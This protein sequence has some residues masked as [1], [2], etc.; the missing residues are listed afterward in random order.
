MMPHIAGLSRLRNLMIEESGGDPSA[1]DPHRLLA[2]F[3][4]SAPAREREALRR[5]GP[6]TLTVR[7]LEIFRDLGM[8]MRA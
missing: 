4:A 5:L 6:D 1:L 3:K 8:G 7:I 2:R